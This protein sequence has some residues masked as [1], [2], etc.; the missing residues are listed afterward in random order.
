MRFNTK[1]GR[2]L[3]KVTKNGVHL[4]CTEGKKGW[5]SALNLMRS[6]HFFSVSFR[7]I[8]T[9]LLRF[10]PTCSLQMFCSGVGHF[11]NTSVR[12]F[13]F[14]VGVKCLL[15]RTSWA[16]LFRKVGLL[17]TATLPVTR[18]VRLISFSSGAGEDFFFNMLT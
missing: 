5:I 2:S 7:L 6:K 8:S 11:P 10:I 1:W 17:T 9:R 13:F 16:K 12:M 18:R 3:T 14:C 15:P 4:L